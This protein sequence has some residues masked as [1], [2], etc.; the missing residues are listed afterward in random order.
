MGRQRLNESLFGQVANGNTKSM[1]FTK[2][3][4]MCFQKRKI[5]QSEERFHQNNM[6][7]NVNVRNEK[8]L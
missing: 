1:K 3:E 5:K 4:I 7:F 6:I 8:C 2:V